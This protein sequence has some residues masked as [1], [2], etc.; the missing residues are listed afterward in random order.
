MAA[1]AVIGKDAAQVGIAGEQHP[2]HVV[3]LALQPARDRPDPRHR[4]HRLHVVRRDVNMQ[5]MITRQRQQ[6]IDHLE[7]LGALRIVDAGD[8]HQLLVFEPRRVAQLGQRIDDRSALDVERDLAD[9][10]DRIDQ[11]RAKRDPDRLDRLTIEIRR[12][13]GSRRPHRSTLP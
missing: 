6:A 2:I 5:A 3:H 1:K 12:I 10:I 11:R 7:P 8:F 13:G 4:R 9:L